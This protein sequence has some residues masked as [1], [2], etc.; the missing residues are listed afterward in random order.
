MSRP[1]SGNELESLRAQAAAIEQKIR[2]ATAR[3]RAKREADDRRRNLLAGQ[4]AL[5]RMK[6]EPHSPFAATLL[7][8]IDGSVRSGG[9]RALF[10]LAPIAKNDPETPPTTPNRDH[11][12]T[13]EN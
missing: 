6:A 9:D 8:L 11:N 3:D 7:G 5:D 1:R 2:E 4:A 13:Q 12:D 10:G